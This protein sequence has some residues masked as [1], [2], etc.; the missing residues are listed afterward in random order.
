LR[1]TVW[2]TVRWISSTLVV[3]AI[4][5]GLPA[6]AAAV[7]ARL[8]DDAHV[9]PT[10]R[11]SN[12]GSAPTL[13]VQGPGP[14]AGQAYVRFDLTSLPAGTRGADV[15]G[16]APIGWPASCAAGCSTFTRAQRWR[17]DD[18]RGERPGPDREE[19]T[20]SRSRRRIGTASSWWTDRG[21]AGVAGRDDREPRPRASATRP[22]SV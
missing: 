19:V 14:S 20:A 4:V 21:R 18:H 12:F 6:A 1:S 17:E 2:S 13:L 5:G 9:S 7:L 15:P 16:D 8:T 22:V 10:A 3:V 11:T